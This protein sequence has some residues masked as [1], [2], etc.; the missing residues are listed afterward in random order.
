MYKALYYWMYSYLSKIK[1]NKTPAFNAFLL[2]VLFEGVN[3]ISIGRIV[4]NIT[5]FQSDDKITIL[6]G[7]VS[8]FSI[9][10]FNFFYLYQ[11]RDSIF[12]EVSK[13]AEGKFKLSNTVFWIYI[14]TS[15]LFIVIVVLNSH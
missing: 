12:I 4:Y 11:K 13:Y 1:T 3:C 5:R 2:I 10:G 9:M 7:A 6:C 14:L 8:V 15:I